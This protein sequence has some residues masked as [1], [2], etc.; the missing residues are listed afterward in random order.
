[1][2]ATLTFDW[3]LFNGLSWLSWYWPTLEV[4][5]PCNPI[6][7]ATL[8]A[9][10]SIKLKGFTPRL[11]TANQPCHVIHHDNVFSHVNMLR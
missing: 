5:K 3:S 2:K 6:H 1:M 7:G 9:W 11:N 10:R 4:V 8:S